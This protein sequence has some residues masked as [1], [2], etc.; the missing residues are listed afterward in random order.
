M[1]EVRN[2]RKTFATPAAEV[3]ALDGVDLT[4]RK[5]DI[6]G[7]V[8]FS[9]S[10]KSTLLRIVSGLLQPTAGEVLWRGTPLAGPPDGVAMVFQSFA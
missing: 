7:I 4:I 6:F 5:G 10:G 1:I 9:G 8:G 2:L 3:L